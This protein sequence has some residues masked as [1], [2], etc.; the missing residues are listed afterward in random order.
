MINIMHIVQSYDISGRSK[1]I[2]E[3][4][5]ALP[6]EQ[7]APIIVC[8]SKG[9]LYAE[10]HKNVQCISLNKNEGLHI[11][12][13]LRLK[14]IIKD[15]HIQIIHTHG[16]A[17]LFYGVMV[18]KW[19]GVK[20]L[21]HSVHRCD[22]DT[23]PGNHWL[24]RILY[25]QV[26][27]VV[28][29]SKAAQAKFQEQHAIDAQRITT[30]YNGIDMDVFE[31][32]PTSNQPERFTFGTVANLSD[33]KDP[34]TLILAFQQILKQVPNSKLLIVGDGPKYSAISR[35]IDRLQISYA[36]QLLGFQHNIKEW[37]SKMQVFIL[38]TK[39]EGLGV[40]LLEAMAAGIPSIASAIGG[41]REIVEHR[42]NG[43]LVPASD[44]TALKEA[45][46]TLYQDPE[47]RRQFQQNG[48][49]TVK[50]KFSRS[51]MLEKYINLYSKASS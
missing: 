39:T 13:L 1:V 28:A 49:Q 46:L 36:V 5:D 17:G 37:L 44:V 50:D 30:I 6:K 48:Y 23:V 33:D 4:S 26:D 10:D 16:R 14:K 22:G 20:T 8:L 41:I 51:Q 42:I 38:A 43:L 34:E 31:N 2:Y 3:L 40:S 25:P 24:G 9:K 32:L 29:V 45:M 21:I 19:A 18:K 47:L 11:S 35:L 12:V 15:H 7:F 27:Q